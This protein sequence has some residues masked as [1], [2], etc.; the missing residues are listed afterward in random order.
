MYMDSKDLIRLAA[1]AADELKATNINLINTIGKSSIILS[2]EDKENA[3]LNKIIFTQS[4]ISRSLLAWLSLI[5]LLI[6]GGFFI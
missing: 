4:V 3:L 5:G 1:L 6:I 2:N